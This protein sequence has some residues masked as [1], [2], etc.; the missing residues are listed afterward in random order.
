[1]SKG[2]E[3]V[4]NQDDDNN[5]SSHSLTT[6]VKPLLKEVNGRNFTTLNDVYHLPFDE[7]EWRRLENQNV[8]LMVAMGGIYPCPEVVEAILSP[9]DGQTKHIIDVGCGTGSWA[10]EMAHRFPHAS[11]LGV[12]V[13]PSPVNPAVLPSNVQF[14][15]CNVN[16]GM[17]RFYDR[18]DLVHVRCI[19]GGMTDMDRTIVE[20][21]RCLK[22]GGMLLI[23]DG[24]PIIYKGRG[25]P[26]GMKKIPGD[27]DVSGVRED[28]SW[29]QRLVTETW[30][31][32][33]IDGACVFRASELTVLGLWDYPLMDPETA[34]SGGVY[35]P[36]GPW[37]QGSTSIET[38]LLQYAGESIRKGFMN[39]HRAYHS[40]L[41]G[42]G[43][44]QDVLNEW[45]RNIDEEL[46]SLRLW[47][48]YP[49]CWARRRAGE[50]LPAPQLSPGSENSCLDEM[51]QEKTNLPVPPEI[52]DFQ[53]LPGYQYPTIE[54]FET[55]EEAH[56]QWSR[57][58]SNMGEM[59]ELIVRKNQRMMRQTPESF[60]PLH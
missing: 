58:K 38:G 44:S 25:I 14:E 28:G 13:V 45:S 9:S 55:K 3:G 34:R 60:S 16:F 40:K 29:L 41:L 12:D 33:T 26:V 47:I 24:E 18:Y 8:A 48:R 32:C 57:T 46:N 27:L 22:P 52:K 23:I 31:G 37:A 36:L 30:E 35:L 7:T 59:P 1:M 6:D 17:S 5:I 42:H 39:I 56:A 43:L 4:H 54:I 19:G 50:G 15:I 11:V 49:F 10:I 51:S 53:R 21:Q 2:Q 20:L